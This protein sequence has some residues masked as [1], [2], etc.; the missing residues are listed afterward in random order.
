MFRTNLLAFL[1]CA[2]Q[3]VPEIGVRQAALIVE[4]WNFNING[5]NSV[6]VYG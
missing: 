1:L 4:A 3:I 5:S 6:I 2:V